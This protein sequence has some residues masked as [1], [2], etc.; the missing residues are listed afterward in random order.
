M[1]A[2]YIHLLKLE[3]EEP[4]GNKQPA[5]T[6]FYFKLFKKPTIQELLGKGE[7]KTFSKQLEIICV[8]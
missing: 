2:Y 5:I 1:E 3:R 6:P 7:F 4:S 8:L